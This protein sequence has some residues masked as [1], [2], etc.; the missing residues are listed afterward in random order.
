MMNQA[1][2]LPQPHAD[3]MQHSRKLCE[4]ITDCINQAGGKIPFSTFM[5]L[6]LYTP[7]LGYYAA[8]AS[9]FGRE[10]DFI[11]A[12]ELSP[13]FGQCIAQSIKPFLAAIS[14]E[15]ILEL[16]AGSGKLAAT[17]LEHCPNI[18]H[19]YILE[20]SAD[21][22]QRQQQ[23]LQSHC[24]QLL[25]KVI[26]LDQLPSQKI[27]GV[28]IANEVMDA[29]PITRFHWKNQQ[30]FEYFVTH[31]QQQF[32]WQLEQ[33]NNPELLSWIEKHYLPDDYMSEFNSM[34]TPWLTSL[35]DCLAQGLILL[36]DYGF[37]RHEFYHPDRNTGTLMCHY[38]H[39]AHSDPFYWPGLQ[40]ITAHVDFT[41][42]AEA[43][44]QTQLQV[45]GFT[46][47]AAFLIECGI[48]EMSKNFQDTQH[49]KMLTMPNEMG[50]LF[51]VMALTRGWDNPIIGFG[52]QDQRFRL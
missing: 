13:L 36:V 1:I 45:S 27:N 21:L 18:T 3:A 12:P 22:K 43:A 29:F 30:L 46:T 17:L 49:I 7:G 40:D 24:P 44:I 25:S 10:G 50:E 41:A 20:V 32:Q 9:K 28:I 34:I 37:P 47:Q 11:T 15:T 16:G 23:T 5:Q 2:T 8:G 51:K 14:A 26:W 4:H 48:L 39:H 6:A 33:Y 38:R 35:S 31:G 19:Y 42:V 52:L